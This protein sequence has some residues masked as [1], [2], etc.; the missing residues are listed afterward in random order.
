MV[1]KLYARDKVSVIELHRSYTA[2]IREVA[3][4]NGWPLID[5]ESEVDALEPEDQG[6]LFIA[7]G[8]HLSA[9]GLTYFANRV[10]QEIRLGVLTRPDAASE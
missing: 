4:V 6:V 7:D 9:A 8:F 2:I 5:L 3:S 1:D 10:V